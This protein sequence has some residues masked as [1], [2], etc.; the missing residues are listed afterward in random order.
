MYD[1]SMCVC[2]L[3]FKIKLTYLITLL[4]YLSNT[5]IFYLTFYV[6]SN[7]TFPITMYVFMFLQRYQ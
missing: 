4:T 3:E 5:R 2:R 6:T 7:G 1:V